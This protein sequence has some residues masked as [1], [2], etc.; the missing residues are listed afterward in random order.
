MLL[1]FAHIELSKNEE[2]CQSFKEYLDNCFHIKDLGKQ[3]FLGIEAARSPNDLL[4]N[5]RKYALDILKETG[6]LNAKPSPTP[7]KQ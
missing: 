7:M 5:Q 6:L 4:L 2:E 3:V 1:E